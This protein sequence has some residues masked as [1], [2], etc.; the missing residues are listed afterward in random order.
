M[1]KCSGRK[2]GDP[3]LMPTYYLPLFEQLK[4]AVE[5]VQQGC[6]NLRRQSASETLSINSPPR[7][8]S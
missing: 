4:V 6:R 2:A 1:A 7:R 5:S 3:L 8:I